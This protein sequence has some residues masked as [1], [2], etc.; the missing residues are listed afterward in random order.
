MSAANSRI[1]E[2]S[3]VAALRAG[4]SNSQIASSFGVT[5]SAVTQFIESHNLQHIAAQNSKFQAIDDKLNSLEETVLDKLGNSMRL[6]VLD[7]I[8]LAAVYKVL[9]GARRRSLSE[10]NTINNFNQIRLVSLNLPQ[11]VQVSVGMSAKNEVIEV[12]G[13]AI[14]TMPAGKLVEL[15]GVKTRGSL[16][17]DKNIAD[18]I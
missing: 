14:N 8:K 4:F 12:D 6:A 1:S 16:S 10:G 2:D 11:H 17:H 13:R 15:A 3:V 18:I 5:D 7:P 9:N